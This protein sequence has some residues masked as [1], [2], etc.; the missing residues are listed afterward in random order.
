MSAV[1]YLTNNKARKVAKKGICEERVLHMEYY[2]SLVSVG[3]ANYA[4]TL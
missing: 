3:E 4:L 2:T 1:N